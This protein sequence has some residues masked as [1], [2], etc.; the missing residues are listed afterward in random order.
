MSLFRRFKAK[1]PADLTVLV[2]G[3]ELCTFHADELPVEKNPSVQIGVDASVSFIDSSNVVHT[4]A[5]GQ[6]LGWAHFSIRL[7]ANKGCQADCV[8]SDSPTF[9]PGA[10]GQGKAIGIRFQPFFLSGAAVAN[11]EFTGKGLFGRGLHFSGSVTPGSVLLSCECDRCH[12]SFLIR[13]YHA[14]FS[15]SGYFYSDSGKYT[16]TVSTRVP[17]SPVPLSTPDPEA[18][19]KLEQSLPEAPDGSRYRYLNPFRC[20]HC[21]E[22]YINFADNPGMRENEYYGNYFAQAQLLRYEPVEA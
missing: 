16:I 15:E 20:P 5:L 1:P 12:R 14:G 9:D 6:A 8:I 19:A 22:P 10:L 4:H 18:L 7:H 13:S 17:G 21:R 2:N 3:M 11:A